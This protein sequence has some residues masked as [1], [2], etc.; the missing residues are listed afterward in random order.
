MTTQTEK[1]FMID[2]ILSDLA[3]YLTRDYGMTIE[4]AL[5]TVYNSEYYERLNNPETGFYCESSPY[6]YRYL[7][8]EIEYGKPA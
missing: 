3:T 4:E 6:N 5:S 8:R 1:N 7:Q 2:C